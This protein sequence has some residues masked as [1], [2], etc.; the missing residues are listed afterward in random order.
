MTDRDAGGIATTEEREARLK[1]ETDAAFPVSRDG[2]WTDW[3]TRVN[4][5]LRAMKTGL[6]N[7]KVAMHNMFEAIA[8]ELADLRKDIA[9]AA[10]VDRQR[11]TRLE[12][13]VAELRAEQAAARRLAELE[14]RLSEIEAHPR[15]SATALRAV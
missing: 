14:Q 10:D 1:R 15:A 4:G 7:Q 6:H 3:A 8:I 5:R 11:I 2:G 12:E 9:R 13:Q